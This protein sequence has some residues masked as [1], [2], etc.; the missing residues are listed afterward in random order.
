M[1]Q[2]K[3]EEMIFGKPLSVYEEELKAIPQLTREEEKTLARRIRQGDESALHELVRAN[4]R[5]LLPIAKQYRGQGLSLEELVNEGNLGLIKAAHRFEEK[6]GYKFISYAVWWIRQAMLQALAEQS[7]LVRLP[8]NRTGTLYRIG[9]AARDLDQ[10]LGR[11]PTGEEIGKA[12]ESP[13]QEGEDTSPGGQE[14]SGLDHDEE[15]TGISP[16]VY[17]QKG[18]PG[19]L[20]EEMKKNF[21]LLT[22]REQL[23]LRLFCGLEGEEPYSLNELVPFFRLTAERLRQIKDKAILRLGTRT[24]S[25]YL[26]GYV[27]D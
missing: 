25:R 19:L 24:R 12:L 1:S 6:R 4:Q 18:D 13:K 2:E 8:M 5:F 10:K 3:P 27:E 14:N 22:E 11:S 20:T 17:D 23:L 16:A 15:G 9:K 21:D 26:K 7:R